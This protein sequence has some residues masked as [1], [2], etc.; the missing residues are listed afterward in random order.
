MLANMFLISSFLVL[1]LSSVIGWQGNWPQIFLTQ[2]QPT[3]YTPPWIPI[4]STNFSSV[5]LSAYVTITNTNANFSLLASLVSNNGTE[6]F[7]SPFDYEAG[8]VSAHLFTTTLSPC[9]VALFLATNYS[10]HYF[11]VTDERIGDIDITVTTTVNIDD[12]VL[13][14]YSNY[15][16]TFVPSVYFRLDVPS[17][18]SKYYATIV[19]QAETNETVPFTSLCVNSHT[20]PASSSDC[21]ISYTISSTATSWNT[22]L[23]ALTPGHYYILLEPNKAFADYQIYTIL[24][25]D[26]ERDNLLLPWY[27]VLLIAIGCIILSGVFVSLLFWRK[28]TKPV[29]IQV[30]S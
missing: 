22:T 20:C 24:Q 7:F 12:S 18:H 2:Q 21:L 13:H 3:A 19:I 26:N 30:H 16:K 11:F 29:Y 4:S 9:T 6:Y 17:N 23:N 27:Y 25:R 15:Y 28:R 1:F 8:G 14:P 10:L 5:T